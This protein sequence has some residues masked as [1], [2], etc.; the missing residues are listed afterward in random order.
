MGETIIPGTLSRYDM[1]NHSYRQ[2]CC[3][4]IRFEERYAEKF[5]N[6]FICRILINYMCYAQDHYIEK[7]EFDVA[8]FLKKK[9]H[10]EY[11]KDDRIS[12]TKGLT[13]KMLEFDFANNDAFK[14]RSVITY[15]IE[16]FVTLPLSEREKIYCYQQ[17]K[18]ILNA[19]EDDEILLISVSSGKEF[20][21]KP[22]T[23]EIDDNSTS[24]YL[25]GF[26]RQK[27]SEKEYECHSFK[28]SRIKDCR[29]K[30]KECVIT[31]KQTKTIK[32][33]SEKFGY[34]Y[35]VRNLTK[36]EI[37]KTIVRLSEKGYKILFLKVIAHQRP[38]PMSEPKSIEIDGE[39]FFDLEFDCS[40]E[41]IRNYFFSFGAEAE[42]M[43]PTSLRERFIREYMTAI[44]RYQTE[45]IQDSHLIH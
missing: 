14:K 12:F 10:D 36:K 18:T 25:I 23:I 1:S 4:H 32:E 11:I 20:E 2:L 17:Y 21:V 19:I 15:I 37:E 13:E 35:M 44:N 33:I 29:S 34:A 8:S 24:F 3:D 30:H 5:G 42:I 39:L 38:I 28:L 41:Q 6:N 22:Y 16:K 31:A 9:R 7:F 26:S 27:G 45:N 43:S 40:Y